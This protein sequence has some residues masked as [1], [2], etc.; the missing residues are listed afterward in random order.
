MKSNCPV[1]I[2]IHAFTLIVLE[3]HPE[4]FI[5]S[6]LR[7]GSKAST[8]ENNL[9]VLISFISE[10]INGNEIKFSTQIGFDVLNILKKN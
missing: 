6:S 1:Q 2:N 9:L 4:S 3:H 8:G 7:T 5:S 10:D